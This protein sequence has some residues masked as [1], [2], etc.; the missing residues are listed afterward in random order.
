ML[1]ISVLTC[2]VGQTVKN[3]CSKTKINGDKK[4]IDKSTD[5]LP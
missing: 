5:K 4:N 3:N 2:T 1:L